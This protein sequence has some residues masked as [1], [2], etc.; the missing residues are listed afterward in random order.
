MQPENVFV[1]V[2]NPSRNHYLPNRNISSA[3]FLYNQ[4]SLPNHIILP[5]LKNY[6]IKTFCSHVFIDSHHEEDLFINGVLCLVVHQCKV[7]SHSSCVQNCFLFFISALPC[8]IVGQCKVVF[9][10]SSLHCCVSLF[11][12]AKLFL[13]LHQCLAV[14]HF[15]SVQSCFI[16][17]VSA[18]L[19]PCVCLVQLLCSRP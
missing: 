5:N 6:C 1:F 8:L 19:C 12:N 4:D 11:V 2:C 14:S 17:F 18:Q 7:D 13:I 10:S 3:I 15:S 16:L 9:Y